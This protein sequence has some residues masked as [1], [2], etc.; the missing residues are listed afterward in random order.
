MTTHER[1][2]RAWLGLAV[3]LA[4]AFAAGWV[5]SAVQGENVAA[6]YLAFER[7]AWA[8]PQE[9]FGIV[10]PVLYLM[11]GVAAWQL[12]RRSPGVGAV[13]T[14]LSLWLGQ[15]VLNAVWPGVFFGAEEFALA[16]AVIVVLDVLVGATV[17]V[18]ARRD[19]VAAALLVPYLLWLLYATALNAALLVLN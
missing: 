16:L 6:R 13:A 10:W 12:W 15:L 14:A 5:G 17:L 18:F 19:R 9:A 3:F 7:P 2:L 4:V 1:P 11:I 8:P